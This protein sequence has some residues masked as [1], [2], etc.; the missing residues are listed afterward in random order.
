S[1]KPVTH[2][3]QEPVSSD[4]TDE[5]KDEHETIIDKLRQKASDTAQKSD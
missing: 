3:E 5:V 4:T 1:R 2:I